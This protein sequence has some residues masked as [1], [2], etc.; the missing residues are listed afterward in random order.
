M[1]VGADEIVGAGIV[2]IVMLELI[3]VGGDRWIAGSLARVYW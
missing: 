3:L 2:L 1:W